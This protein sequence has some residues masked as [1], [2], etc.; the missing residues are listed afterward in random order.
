MIQIASEKVVSL[1]RAARHFPRRRRGKRPHTATLYRWAKSG[2][3]AD[4]G[5]AVVLETIRVG[6]T[7]CTSVE[8]IQRFCERVSTTNTSYLQRHHPVV[9]SQIDAATEQAARSRGL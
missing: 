4:D 3:R 9:K 2:V 1:G 6:R 8:A 7:L 5:D